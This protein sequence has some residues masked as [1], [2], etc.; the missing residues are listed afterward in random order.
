[1]LTWNA[2]VKLEN[3]AEYVLR[4]EA[5][6][7]VNRLIEL[8]DGMSLQMMSAM[9]SGL[10]DERFISAR[11]NYQQFVYQ[12]GF[13]PAQTG[14]ILSPKIVKK[15]FN[16]PINVPTPQRIPSKNHRHRPTTQV[17]R[18]VKKKD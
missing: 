2:S 1:M 11:H 10:D 7:V 9:L 13:K 5:D 3:G 8:A 15:S 6:A 17:G 12:N 16:S 18:N 14:E 4:S